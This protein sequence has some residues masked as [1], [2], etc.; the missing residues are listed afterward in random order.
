MIKPTKRRRIMNN[1]TQRLKKLSEDLAA[2]ELRGDAAFL[3]R[4]L[5]DD[6][7]GVGPRGFTLTKEQ[8]IARHE[9]GNLKY[10]SFGVDDVEIR[11]YEDAAVAVC[12]QSA[13]RVY[14]DDNGRFDIHEQFRETLVFVKQ[15][16]RWL[17]TSLHLSPIAGR[18][19][20]GHSRRRTLY[21]RFPCGSQSAAWR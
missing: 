7:V 4:A 10:E 3:E 17:L 19:Y 2:A 21:G 9:A 20:V 1:E 8:W 16:G 18:P 5:A 15:Q 12:R 6:F 11:P 13:E 14:E